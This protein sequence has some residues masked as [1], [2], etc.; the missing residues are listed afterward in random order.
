MLPP[1][2]PE[3]AAAVVET[4]LVEGSV[5]SPGRGVQP[6]CTYMNSPTSPSLPPLPQSTSRRSSSTVPPPAPRSIDPGQPQHQFATA[7]RHRAKDGGQE[8]SSRLS[9]ARGSLA[10]AAV[11]I[12]R[13][14]RPDQGDRMC[15]RSRSRVRVPRAIPPSDADGLSAEPPCGLDRPRDLDDLPPWRASRSELETDPLGAFPS[16]SSA[17]AAQGFRGEDWWRGLRLQSAGPVIR[18]AM[19]AAS[20]PELETQRARQRREDAAC[21][22]GL[23]HPA[24]LWGDHPSCSTGPVT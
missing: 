8:S 23:R 18:H 22:A 17:D 20:T 15:S 4:P 1:T 19:L 5:S 2:Q 11:R 3:G 7:P 6:P 10:A 14:L 16:A 24:G 12:R 21:T 13:Q 9:F